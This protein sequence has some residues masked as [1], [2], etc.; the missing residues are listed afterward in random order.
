[1][2]VA[3]TRVTLGQ[4]IPRL[5]ARESEIRRESPGDGESETTT[6]LAAGIATGATDIDRTSE[7]ASE[8]VCAEHSIEQSELSQRGSRQPARVAIT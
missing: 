7:R 3:A 8:V 4:S 5:D 1:V 2:I 6:R